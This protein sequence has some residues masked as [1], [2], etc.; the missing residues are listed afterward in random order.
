MTCYGI[1]LHTL[2]SSNNVWPCHSM[3]VSAFSWGKHVT[4]GQTGDF[5]R[6]IRNWSWI[7]LRCS[8]QFST[9]T[10]SQSMDATFHFLGGSEFPRKTKFRFASTHPSTMITWS[11]ISLK[12]CLTRWR[13]PARL[14][15]PTMASLSLNM[16]K[17]RPCKKHRKNCECLVSQLII[18][19]KCIFG[20][21]ASS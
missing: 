9:I 17:M 20:A 13:F 12:P 3:G 4:W 2:T 16:W 8:R 7:L 6:R 1:T 15:R 14:Q 11:S 10:T 5:S 19:P 18:F 21:Y